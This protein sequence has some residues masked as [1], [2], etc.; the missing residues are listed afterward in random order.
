MKR[1]LR[2]F[3][4]VGAL[5][6]AVDLGVYVLLGRALDNR[7]VL[8]DIAALLIAAFASFAVHRAVTFHDDA[9]ALIDHQARSFAMAALPAM[10]TDLV[11]VSLFVI[12]ASLSAGAMLAV[13]VLAIAVSATVRM[14]TYRGALFS[15]VRDRQQLVE[16]PAAEGT[17]RLS[18]VLPAY[19]AADVVGSSISRLRVALGAFE[20]DVELV[21][22]DDG[23][24]DGTAEA[25]RIAGAD[26]VIE[27]PANRGKGAAVRA[28]MLAARGR[29]V[30]FTDI[31]LAYPPEQIE[32]LVDQVE[33]GW[34][35][36]VGSR[37]HPETKT[38]RRAG[39]FREL[40]SFGFNL[41]TYFVLLGN[42]RDTQCGLKAFRSGAAHQIFS[43]TIIDGFAF[44]V[45]VLHLAERLGLSLTEK[46]VVL[47]HV[48]A[49]TVKLVPQATQMLRDVL[50]V[51]RASATGQY[52]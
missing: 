47:D 32:T 41:L 17:V 7:W 28:G 25:A 5:I 15:A 46:A 49:T 24:A 31:D 20:G 16:L 8:A 42:Y 18:V 48:E 36:V 29:A 2:R 12:V 4:F 27:L 1:R 38:V 40:G 10:A 19:N 37:R 26:Q 23:S 52:D 21:I 6:T 11:V 22:V 30:V 51:R 50:K 14:F 35:V 13:K 43:R 9:Y 33:A 3:L 39:R 44:D 45:E 34:Q